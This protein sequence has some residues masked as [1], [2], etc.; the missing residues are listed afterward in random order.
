LLEL[1]LDGTSNA[2]A[3]I[4][5]A[6]LA[7]RLGVSRTP[8]R[9]ALGRLQQEGLI[10]AEPNKRP[11][12]VGLDPDDLEIVYASRVFYETLGLQQ[13]APRLGREELAAIEGELE[14]MREAAQSD[15]CPVWEV[16]H[17]KF[18]GLLAL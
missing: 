8:L 11:R 3:S 4:S 6:E 7:V 15:D 1:I 2:D 5:Q 14:A 10:S 13:T 18:H 16:A 9:E 12:L 17:T